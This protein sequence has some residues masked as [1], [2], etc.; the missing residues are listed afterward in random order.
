MARN[1]IHADSPADPAGLLFLFLKEIED[2]LLY[3][4]KQIRD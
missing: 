2:G 4:Y 1:H 3:T